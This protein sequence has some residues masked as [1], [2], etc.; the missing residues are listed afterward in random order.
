MLPDA[1]EPDG[2]T[3][4]QT[5]SLRVVP[6][7][8]TPRSPVNRTTTRSPLVLIRDTFRSFKAAC[9]DPMAHPVFARRSL[10]GV[11]EVLVE[12]RLLVEVATPAMLADYANAVQFGN[13]DRMIGAPPAAP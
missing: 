6:G 7:A 12:N 3:P 5:Q 2:D 9:H 1:P 8:P 11:V 10:G 13:I 4:C